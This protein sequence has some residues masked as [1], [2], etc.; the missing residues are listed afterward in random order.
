MFCNNIDC[1]DGRKYFTSTVSWCS[2]FFLYYL[3]FGNYFLQVVNI[4]PARYFCN[5]SPHLLNACN[6][7]SLV[8]DSTILFLGNRIS[9]IS[10]FSKTLI[11]K[12][13]ELKNILESIDAQL[14][15]A[16]ELQLRHN[17][18]VDFLKKVCVEKK[19]LTWYWKYT[20]DEP[21]D[22]NPIYQLAAFTDISRVLHSCE[23][24]R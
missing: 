9:S 5:T 17:R 4:M 20:V 21:I 14:R 12:Q 6:K 23:C 24:N 15:Q 8:L 22:K 13:T 19:K 10:P 16:D 7:F 11:G 1:Y 18:L 2:S 3:Y